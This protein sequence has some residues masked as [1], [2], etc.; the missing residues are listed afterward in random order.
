MTIRRLKTYTGGQGYVYQYYYVG[1]RPATVGLSDAPAV[2]Y[3]FDVTADRKTMFSVS[4]FVPQDTLRGWASHHGRELTGAEEYAAVN[5]RLM[6]RMGTKALEALGQ[7]EITRR[8]HSVGMPPWKKCWP[9][10]GWPRADP[11]NCDRGHN[12][13]GQGRVPPP[14][15]GSRL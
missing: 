3:V 13:W 10:W 6:T 7:G 8:L 9:R 5:M 12:S 1:K 15:P 2:E 14:D 4:I 11:P